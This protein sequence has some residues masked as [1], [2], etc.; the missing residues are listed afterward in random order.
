MKPVYV[1]IDYPCSEQVIDLYRK[2]I[3]VMVYSG[4]TAIVARHG[5]NKT[6]LKKILRKHLREER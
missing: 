5:V 4:M 3:V 2:K 6:T 1:L